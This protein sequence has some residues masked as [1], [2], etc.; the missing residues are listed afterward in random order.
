MSTVVLVG[1]GATLAES[2][3]SR[4]K[5]SFCPPLDSTFFSLCEKAKLTGRATVRTYMLKH[6]G[7]D[8]SKGFTMETVFG[9]LYS[10]VFSASPPPGALEAYWALVRMYA[11][12]IARTTNRLRGRSRSGIGALMRTLL[13]DDDDISLVTFNQDLVIEKA[14]ESIS[15]TDAY[16]DVPWNILSCYQT[17]FEEFLYPL[18]GRMFRARGGEGA[19]DPSIH[20]FKLHGSL[21]WAWRADTLEDARNSISDPGS[22]VY[23]LTSQSVEG[24]LELDTATRARYLV[25]VVVPPIY[26]KGNHFREFLGPLWSGARDEIAR[27]D[28]LVVFGYSFPAT[29]FNARSLLKAAYHSSRSLEEVIVIDTN[30]YVSSELTQLLD[31]DSCHQFR[32]V[33]AYRTWVQRDN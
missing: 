5:E 8:P 25:P 21:N 15:D 17:E 10:D 14:L 18:D 29:D 33:P 20:I 1:A 12:A 4:P 11:A 28:R 27:A 9:Y 26:E 6:F 2:L 23:C 16:S 13:L 7:I 3:P 31:L 30:P 19:T 24:D 32:S 22:R